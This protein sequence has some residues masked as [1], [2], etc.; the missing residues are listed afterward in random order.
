MDM[1]IGRRAGESIG[2][3]VREPA[4]VGAQPVAELAGVAAPQYVVE[5]VAIVVADRCHLPAVRNTCK[6][7]GIISGEP[8]IGG[9]QPVAKVTAVAAPQNVVAAIAVEVAGAGDVPAGRDIG[10]G[11][12]VIGREPAIG[13][14]EPVAEVAA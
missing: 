4:A 14:A 12:G 13:G 3:V 9:A 6:S 1:P 10:E 7:V 2:V 8:A 5:P 11:I